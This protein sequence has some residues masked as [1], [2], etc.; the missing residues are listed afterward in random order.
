M[1][2]AFHQSFNAQYVSFE[3]L[4]SGQFT[5][6]SLLIKPN[7]L[8]ISHQCSTIVS[9]PFH[10]H[11]LTVNS[12][13]QLLHISLKK[14]IYLCIILEV[15]ACSIAKYFYSLFVFWLTLQAWQNTA[16]L[17]KIQWYYTPKLLVWYIYIYSMIYI[18]IHSSTV[19]KCTINKLYFSV[20]QKM[21]IMLASM[22][23]FSVNL[24]L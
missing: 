12:P 7:K 5:S 19:L 23:F 8:V 14:Y 21:W 20:C 17:V 11:N 9:L 13:F 2:G 6:S 24:I 3:T 16:Q 10:S 1:F 18:Y 22:I 4:N 15:L